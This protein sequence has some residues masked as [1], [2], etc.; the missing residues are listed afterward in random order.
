VIYPKARSGTAHGTAKKRQSIVH[1]IDTLAW[2]RRKDHA[3]KLQW[4]RATPAMK[5]DIQEQLDSAFDVHAKKVEQLRHAKEQKES[6]EDAFVRTFKEC[7]TTLMK[8]ALEEI[9][10]YLQTKSMRTLIEETDESAT[11]GVERTS[12]TIY[13]MTA[14][15]RFGSQ[16]QFDRREPHLSILCDR[17]ATLVQFFES[18]IR[19]TS[20][21]HS[22]SSAGSAK[23]E[24]LTDDLIHQKVLAIVLA[25]L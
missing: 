8:P 4:R 1:L 15:E 19:G 16:Q 18:R 17:H 12:I 9:A 11:R 7:R 2:L 5:K 24:D 22:G 10:K 23:L 25:V 20:A 14:D 21:G 6:K 3:E 13:L